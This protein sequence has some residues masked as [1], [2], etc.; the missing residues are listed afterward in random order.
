[1]REGET[2]ACSANTTDGTISGT[3]FYSVVNLCWLELSA[4]SYGFNQCLELDEF[5]LFSF[6]L[7]NPSSGFSSLMYLSTYYLNP[8]KAV[9]VSLQ[10]DGSN[11][12][13]R[14]SVLQRVLLK[15]KQ[16]KKA[17][18]GQTCKIQPWWLSLWIKWI[19]RWHSKKDEVKWQSSHGLGKEHVF[20]LGPHSCTWE[21]KIQTANAVLWCVFHVQL[22][23][24]SLLSFKKENAR[25]TDVVVF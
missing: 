14:L 6:S 13:S 4:I 11:K 15:Q 21:C 23:E 22:Y 10:D 19:H 24:V 25:L 7:W 18:Q 20:R 3:E 17:V 5:D 12:M 9:L 16:I 1:M 2:V 8:F